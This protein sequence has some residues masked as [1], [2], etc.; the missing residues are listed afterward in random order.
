MHWLNLTCSNVMFLDANEPSVTHG[1]RG[2]CLYKV[3]HFKE[4]QLMV[5]WWAEYLDSNNENH[6]TPYEFGRR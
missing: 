2:A 6:L 5:Q 3:G 1:V 4:H